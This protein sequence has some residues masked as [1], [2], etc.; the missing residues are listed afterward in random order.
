MNELKAVQVQGPLHLTCFQNYVVMLIELA[1]EDE[2][3]F[4]RDT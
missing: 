4:I 2:A 1:M 3:D